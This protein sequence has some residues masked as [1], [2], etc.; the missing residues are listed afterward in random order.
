MQVPKL[1]QRVK[2]MDRAEVFIVYRVCAAEQTADL[3]C[4]GT[5]TVERHVRWAMLVPAA[6]ATAQTRA[7]ERTGSIE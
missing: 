7:S 5:N 3:V 2:V 6:E 4:L 1:L